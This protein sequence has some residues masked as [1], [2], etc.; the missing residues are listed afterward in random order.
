MARV[1]GDVP[2]PV[3]TQGKTVELIELFN[4]L[5]YVYAI[6]K[7]TGL[8]EHPASGEIGPAEV[9]G[10]L[11]ACLVVLQ[12]WLFQT[13][14]VNRFGRSSWPEHLVVCVNMISALFLSNTISGD[15][16]VTAAPFAASMFT[17]LGSTAALYFMHAA[18]KEPGGRFARNVGM[19]LAALAVA[20]LALALAAPSL[21]SKAFVVFPIMVVIGALAPSFVSGGFDSAFVDA[22]HLVERFE[23]LVVLTFG[24]T[25]VTM[26]G[27]FDASAFSI[28][29]VLVFVNVLVLFGTYVLFVH[30]MLDHRLHGMRGLVLMYAHFAM[31]IGL[32]LLTVALALTQEKGELKAGL[33]ALT[34][35][36]LLFYAALL[37]CSVYAREGMA[38]TGADFGLVAAAIAMGIAITVSAA[39]VPYGMLAGVLVTRVGVFGVLERRYRAKR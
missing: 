9:L 39:E 36:T 32:N 31:I 37:A 3:N 23:L 17:M 27:I 21:P 35:S 2:S 14:Y 8:L 5:M 34:V 19:L 29:P 15:W 11:V 6:S 7:M 16:A 4:D 38:F 1:D 10:W 25:V 33:V 30:H 20:Y 13:N 24:E 12:A 18:R 22:R 28:R 26:A